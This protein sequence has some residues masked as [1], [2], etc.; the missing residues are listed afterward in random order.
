MFIQG[1][2]DNFTFK[3]NLRKSFS[4]NFR[5]YLQLTKLTKNKRVLVLLFKQ[6]RGRPHITNKVIKQ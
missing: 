1:V 3:R 6:N 4:R 2:S 5:I